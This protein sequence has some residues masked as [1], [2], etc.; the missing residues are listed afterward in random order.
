MTTAKNKE[1]GFEEAMAR[2]EKIVADMEGGEL[3]LEQ[4]ITRF[5]EGQNLI[6]S[7]SKT[8]NEVERKIEILVKKGDTVVA[9][10]FSDNETA[11]DE[12]DLF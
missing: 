9:E 12:E 2:L 7:C 4:M 11:N 6:K 5:E 1:P 8:L 10:P 3:S